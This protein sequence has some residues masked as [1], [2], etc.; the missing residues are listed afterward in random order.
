V[1]EIK[2]VNRLG[3]SIE[4]SAAARIASRRRRIRRRI[5]LGALGF[6]VAATGVA[7]ASGVFSSPEQLASTSIACY[8]RASLS[9]NVAVLSAGGQTPIETCRRVLKTDAQLIA[10]ADHG[11]H[12]FPGGP[13]TCDKLGME[14]LPREYTA[15]RR[16]VTA[17]ARDVMALEK[18]TDCLPPQ[19]FARR[20]DALLA[21]SGWSGWRTQLRL[22]VEDGPCGTVSS[23]GGDGRR[24]VEGALDV[25]DRR[26]M[27][28]GTASRA[29][30][31][32]LYGPHGIAGPAMDASGRRCYTVEGVQ[33]LA[34]QRL[35]DAGRPLSFTTGSRPAETDIAGER[36]DR[37]DQGCAVI[38]GLSTTPEDRILVEIW[39]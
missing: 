18:R 39:R 33:A 26:V 31:D 32:L 5:T 1:S 2:F 15:A 34:R 13:A 17:F 28:F 37:L 7:A 16:R 3:D 30:T 8:E 9:A 6:A 36:G 23:Q 25:E 11:V 35:A 27:V 20:V 19:E 10:C 29:L 38:V 12:V 14:P 24:T 4:R 21:R 22:D